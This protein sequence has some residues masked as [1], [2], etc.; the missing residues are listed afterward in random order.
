MTHYRDA[1]IANSNSISKRY[2]VHGDHH[3]YVENGHTV[4]VL[5]KE[6]GGGGPVRQYAAMPEFS[7]SAINCN[8]PQSV[9]NL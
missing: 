4:R 7:P 2:V 8:C 1:L 9:D 3:H 5:S 6:A